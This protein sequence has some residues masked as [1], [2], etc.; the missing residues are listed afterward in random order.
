MNLEQ[1]R[2]ARGRQAAF[3]NHPEDLVLLHHR[4]LATIED[5]LTILRVGRDTGHLVKTPVLRDRRPSRVNFVEEFSST[6]D[7][8]SF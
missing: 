8:L 2:G 6:E 3:K 7:S 4:V 5:A 1:P